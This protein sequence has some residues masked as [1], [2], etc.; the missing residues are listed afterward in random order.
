MSVGTP[1]I[2]RTVALWLT[3]VLSVRAA[4]YYVAVSGND[5]GPGTAEQPFRTITHAYGKV[6]PGDTIIVK[7]GTYTDY[8][9]KYG[10]HLNNRSGSATQRITLKSEKKWGAVLDGEYRADRRN[11]I[12]LSGSYH[13][14]DGFEMKNGPAGAME[15][16][17]SHNTIINNHI[18]HNGNHA[19]PADTYGKGGIYTGPGTKAHRHIGNY[20]HHNG[21]TNNVHDHGLY[22]CGDDELV[23]NNILA[24]HGGAGLQVAGYK[25]VSNLQV[26][27]NVFA[28]NDKP[29][30]WLWKPVDGIRI[31]NN[32]FFRNK[33]FGID[34]Y[35]ARGGGVVIEHNLF[36]G[37][38]HGLTR[39]DWEG[40]DF[41]Y[42]LGTNLTADPL[43]ANPDTADFRLRPGSPAI[44]AGAPLAEVGTDFE[45]TA[46]P[47][48][49]A[50]DI[51]AYEFRGGAGR[52]E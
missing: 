13:T 41:T 26:Y 25:T 49:A 24:H 32:I 22:L 5:A 12:F 48:G 27:H 18:H 40:S 19:D 45:G 36:W 37:N 4:A 6:S 16:W 38:R 21:R 30:I 3:A 15:I 2:L 1:L 17:G 47:Q 29:G 9:P 31:R 35:H 23:A 11:V 43:F 34:S 7:P 8:R 39:L 42:T 50:W 51:G 44:D 52:E 28:F 46:R 33:V 20:I 14:I 10:L